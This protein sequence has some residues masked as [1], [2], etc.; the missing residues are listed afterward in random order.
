[1]VEIW[2]DDPGLQRFP[3]LTVLPVGG[4]GLLHYQREF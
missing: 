4:G 1:M 2:R 3:R